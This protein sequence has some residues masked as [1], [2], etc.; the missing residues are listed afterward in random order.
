MK[1]RE[2]ASHEY[3]TIYE[4]G[5]REWAKGRSFQQYIQDNQ[6]EE[7]YGKRYVLVDRDERVRASL[8]M[9]K[10][11]PYLFGIGSIVV[12]PA[13][14]GQGAGMHLIKECLKLHPDAA[15]LLYS[16][17]GA[18]YYGR[19]GFRILPETHQ[20]SAQSICMLRAEEGLYKRILNEP[21]PPY[22]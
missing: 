6:K 12:D 17:I 3:H 11:K 14:R 20:P 4:H 15:I 5:Y 13:F 18:P 16:E 19:F 7:A 22:F 10:F 21:I 8:I 2:A 1:V 9:L